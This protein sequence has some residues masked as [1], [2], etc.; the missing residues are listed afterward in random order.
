MSDTA[1]AMP[2]EPCPQCAGRISTRAIE[3]PLCGW[4]RAAPQDESG[5]GAVGA[6]ASW[7]G[8]GLALLALGPASL[9]GGLGGL[10]ASALTGPDREKIR[11]KARKIAA[12]DGFPISDSY[13]ALITRASFWIVDGTYSAEIPFA[14][15]IEVELASDRT[16]QPSLLQNASAAIRL[17]YG[18][19]MAASLRDGGRSGRSRKSMFSPAR[20]P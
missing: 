13:W 2:V 8:A 10:F 3:C 18:S 19:D 4:V 14:D 6:A 15:L 20:I 12:V 9:V 16:T 1:E 17:T 5:G 7:A 11:K